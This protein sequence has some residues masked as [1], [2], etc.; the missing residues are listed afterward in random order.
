MSVTEVLHEL[1]SWKPQDRQALVRKVMELDEAGLTPEELKLAETRLEAH[2]K[3]PSSSLS[4]KDVL[5]QL[6]K[7]IAR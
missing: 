7:L 1:P 2:R 5:G 4:A 3:D 6:R